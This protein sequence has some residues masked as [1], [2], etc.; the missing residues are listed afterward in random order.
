MQKIQLC[1]K[2]KKEHRTE[3]LQELPVYKITDLAG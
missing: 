1:V 3:S 2:M